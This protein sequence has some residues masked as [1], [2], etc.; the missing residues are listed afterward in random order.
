VLRKVVANNAA[1]QELRRLA[2]GTLR[3]MAVS[4]HDQKQVKELLTFEENL[5]SHPTAENAGTYPQLLVRHYFDMAKFHERNADSSEALHYYSLFRANKGYTMPQSQAAGYTEEVV[6]FNLGNCNEA[7]GKKLEAESMF[8]QILEMKQKTFDRSY[9]KFQILKNKSPEEFQQ[10]ASAFLDNEQKDKWTP[11][12][13]HELGLSYYHS[14]KYDAAADMFAKAIENVEERERK[15]NNM[16]LL[17]ESLYYLGKKSEAA[18]IFNMLKR[19]YADFPQFSEAIAA[20][21]GTLKSDEAVVKDLMR[22]AEFDFQQRA[23][24]NVDASLRTNV[25][26]SMGGVTTG[27]A[28]VLA[29]AAA[30]PPVAKLGGP[31]QRSTWQVV[32]VCTIACVVAAAGV[33]ILFVRRKRNG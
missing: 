18:D 17:G 21:L 30:Q 24:A 32:A 26:R 15:A 16:L 11:A 27:P 13:M 14:G 12:L 20:F 19:D 7:L 6:L 23:M 25:Q 10:G 1:D 2:A 8:Q 29:Q 33:R 3:Q 5:L 28:Q 4:A 9:I 22:E 31:I